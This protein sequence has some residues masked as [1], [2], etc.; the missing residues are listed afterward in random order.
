MNIAKKLKDL[1]VVRRGG[2]ATAL[3]PGSRYVMDI[4]GGLKEVPSSDDAAFEA[5]AEDPNAL[6]ML[7]DRGDLRQLEVL[8]R[9]MSVLF[10][11]MADL[12]E[13]YDITP[14]ELSAQVT[15]SQAYD[16]GGIAFCSEVRIKTLEAGKVSFDLL[17]SN[18]GTDYE[19]LQAG[20]THEFVEGG[21]QAKLT[22][23]A[24]LPKYRY[25]KIVQQDPDVPEAGYNAVGITG[26]VFLARQ[27]AVSKFFPVSEYGELEQL[28][29]EQ[30]DLSSY[31]DGKPEAEQ[32]LLVLVSPLALYIR[33]D[34]EGFVLNIGTP[35]TAPY[36][37]RVMHNVDEIG[38]LDVATNGATSFSSL[39]KRLVQ[40]GDRI[41]L[42]AP[43]SPDETLADVSLTLSLERVDTTTGG[44]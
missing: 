44:L 14:S 30:Y 18:N 34:F 35:P 22:V 20:M 36:Q 26:V 28:A 1:F 42:L 27:K 39:E 10:N 32:K 6:L 11:Q 33:Q 12:N 5:A 21:V 38:T 41:A 17:G 25:F 40:P 31:I 37:I 23:R 29:A 24:D 16:F 9:N 13:L 7:G 4:N 2:G 8:T 43:P 3:K 19:L 15:N